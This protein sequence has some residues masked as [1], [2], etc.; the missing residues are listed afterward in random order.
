[1]SFTLTPMLA[2]LMLP[3]KLKKNKLIEWADLF[4]EKMKAIYVYTL[5]MV[6]DTKWRAV[7]TIVGSFAM[8]IAVTMIFILN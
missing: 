3:E 6:M 2:K 1:M 7:A 5:K 4:E 8:F